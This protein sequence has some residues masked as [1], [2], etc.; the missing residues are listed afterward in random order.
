MKHY[1]VSASLLLSPLTALHASRTLLEI[2]GFGKR[3]CADFRG[4]ELTNQMK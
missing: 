2:P 1:F 3:R 4:L